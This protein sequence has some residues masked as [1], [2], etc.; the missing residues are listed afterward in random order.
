MHLQFPDSTMLRQNIENNPHEVICGFP[1]EDPYFCKIKE[2]AIEHL[3]NTSKTED[4]LMALAQSFYQ[5]QK[6]RSY[7]IV[8]SLTDS[9]NLNN[10]EIDL[11]NRIK[12]V[13]VEFSKIYV[14]ET[15]RVK[16]LRLN[17][18]YDSSISD[19]Y[20]AAECG[21]AEDARKIIET[22]PELVN[23]TTRLGTSPLHVAAH[24]GKLEIIHLL[25]A[26]GANLQAED[27]NGLMPLDFAVKAILPS[28][29]TH[30]MVLQ[31]LFQ[32]GEKLGLKIENMSKS[33]LL[34]EACAL[35][36]EW[37]ISWLF[38]HGVETEKQGYDSLKEVVKQGRDDI[39]K[40]MLDKKIPVDPLVPG[41]QSALQV[42]VFCDHFDVFLT[43]VKAGANV[44]LRD[45][46]GV[47][48]LHVAALQGKMRMLEILIEKGADINIQDVNGYTPIQYAASGK[49]Q[50]IVTKLRALGAK[51]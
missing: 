23:K 39:V 34:F 38:K 49:Q 42:A 47:A 13:L 48:P 20:I 18:S 12:D 51:I 21:F 43:L 9:I 17:N 27:K 6:G 29:D 5:I 40:L 16:L 46:R 45:D 31:T 3:S 26:A 36:K 15:D 1:K 50:T 32:A 41:E 19:L 24:K 35:P 28:D 33:H 37:L 44:N 22:Q 2:L 4:E 11:I 8:A 25:L 7:T 10:P 30:F 14:K